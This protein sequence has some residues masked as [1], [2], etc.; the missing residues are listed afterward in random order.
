MDRNLEEEFIDIPDSSSTRKQKKVDNPILQ[1]EEKDLEKEDGAAEIEKDF[2][3]KNDLIRSP[4][5][6][7]PD[8]ASDA[9]RALVLYTPESSQEKQESQVLATP[10]CKDSF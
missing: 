5:A 4:A 10:T 8:L 7:K 3:V 6:T 9:L 2:K 1:N